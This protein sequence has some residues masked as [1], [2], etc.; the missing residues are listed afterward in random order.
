[1]RLPYKITLLV[2]CT[3]LLR[4][5]TSEPPVELDP[6]I[7]VLDKAVH[8]LL[9]GVLTAI[10][11]MGMY[12]SRRDW[13]FCCWLWAPPGL[14]SLYGVVLETYQHFLPHRGFDP[15]DIMAN[16]IGAAAAQL[17]IAVIIRL[18]RKTAGCDVGVV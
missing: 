1:M 7:P 16:C 17:G 2:Y 8:A 12:R 6:G 18:S 15:W 9:F 5:M 3:L 13:P 11:S 14:A 10:I 4:I